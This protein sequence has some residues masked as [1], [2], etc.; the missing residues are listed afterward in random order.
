MFVSE[1]LGNPR[2]EMLG[3]NVER[4]ADCIEAILGD[5][6]ERQA[7]EQG[8]AEERRYDEPWRLNM[9]DPQEKGITYL[10]CLC[11]TLTQYSTLTNYSESWTSCSRTC[12]A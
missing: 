7:S 3:W 9:A 8:V 6:L 4:V 11:C 2:H 1:A 10:C 12:L 5:H